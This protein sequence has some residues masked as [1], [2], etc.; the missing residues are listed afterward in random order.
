MPVG[1]VKVMKE[2]D[3]YEILSFYI[4]EEHRGKGFG[5]QAIIRLSR[6]LKGEK[7]RLWVIRRQ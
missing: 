3:S 7:M 4:L 2:F 5:K 1:V 6:L